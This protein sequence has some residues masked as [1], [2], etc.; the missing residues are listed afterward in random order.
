MENG[1]CGTAKP[2][3]S[4]RPCPI[5]DPTHPPTRAAPRPYQPQSALSRP[6]AS[7]GAGDSLHRIIGQGHHLLHH[8][9]EDGHAQIFEAAG[10][11]VAAQLDPEVRQANLLAQPLGPEQVGVPLKH[12]DD[13]VVGQVGDDPLFHGP[14]AAAVGPLGAARALVEQGLPLLGA[15]LAQG[16]Q[17]VVDLQQAAACG[18]GVDDIVNGVAAG[19][20]PETA[21]SCLCVHGVD[22]TWFGW[23]APEEMFILR[24]MSLTKAF[25][26]KADPLCPKNGHS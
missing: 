24:V 12:A 23:I 19:A 13:V 18:A 5:F 7:A 14:D 6:V 22:F 17:V 8:A 10:V 21:K 16:L 1:R 26:F 25:C 20:A 15:A 11:A 9:D 2:A 3:Q 4:A